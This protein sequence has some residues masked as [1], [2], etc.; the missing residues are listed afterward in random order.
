MSIK[1]YSELIK[2]KSYEERFRYLNL[3]GVVGEDTFGRDRYINQI[4]YNSVEWKNI[5]RRCILRDNGCDLG[6]EGLTI[7]KG[8]TLVVHHMNPITLVDILN[9]SPL[10]YDLEYLICVTSSTH[11]AIHYGNEGLLLMEHEER[12]KFDTCPWKRS[13]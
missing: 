3:N 8:E 10:V 1:T 2:Y 4:F 13:T 9:K 11:K 7:H 12:S 5:R 6:V